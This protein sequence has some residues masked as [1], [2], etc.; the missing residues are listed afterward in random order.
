M[1]PPALFWCKLSNLALSEFVD[2]KGNRMGTHHHLSE[3]LK[4]GGHA[5]QGNRLSDLRSTLDV[6]PKRLAAESGITTQELLAIEAGFQR[7]SPALAMKMTRLLGLQFS[8]LWIA[9]N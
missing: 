3:R 4:F 5:I 9:P 7:L 8:D 6:C 2:Q 1:P